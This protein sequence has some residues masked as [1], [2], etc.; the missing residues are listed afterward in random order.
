MKITPFYFTKISNDKYLISNIFKKF[1]FISKAQFE[2][3][4]LYSGKINSEIEE[5]LRNY[6][7]VIDDE[8]AAAN[9][10]QKINSGLF[11]GTFLHIFVLTLECNLKCLYC[12]AEYKCAGNSSMSIDTAKHAV[13]IALQSPEKNLSFEF[14]GGE[15][16]LNFEALKFII[17]YSN[18]RKSGKN[19]KYSLVTNAQA[20]TDEIL[21]YLSEHDVNICFSLDG[22]KYVH[23]KNRPSKNGK[24]NFENVI[25]WHSKAMKLYKNREQKISALPTITKYTLPYVKELVDFYV[26]LGKSYISIRPLSPFGRVNE[27]HD[28][29]CYTPEEF[30]KFYSECMN[31]IIE[32]NL[33]GKSS[34]RESFSEII[35]QKIVGLYAVNYTDLRSP[36]GAVIGQIAYNW[37]GNI[38]SCDEGRMMSNIGINNFCIGNVYRDSYKSCLLSEN[39]CTICNA[40]CIETNPSCSECVFNPICGLCPAYSFYVQNDFVGIPVKQDRCKIL[41]GIFTY[42]INWLNSENK[43]LCVQWGS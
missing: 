25:K 43:D 7:F 9:Y 14:Q 10:Y 22:P 8:E 36:C 40:S 34:I 19:I 20:M 16:L 27:N 31:Y 3:L 30:V 33:T 42:L 11:R 28:E 6:K 32:L 15:P 35:L 17:E 37:D 38:Y 24:S 21:N 41:R 12:Q 39:S 18:S 1:M 29:L 4:Y 5:D 13:D 26:E 2:D 23:D